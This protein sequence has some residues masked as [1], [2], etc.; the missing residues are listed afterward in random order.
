MVSLH[1]LTKQNERSQLTSK[2]NQ[3]QQK[4]KIILLFPSLFPMD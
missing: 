1:Y 3:F 2:K 4:A